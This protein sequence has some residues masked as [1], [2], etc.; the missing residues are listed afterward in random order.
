[1]KVLH[2]DKFEDSNLVEKP[3]HTIVALGQ[4]SRG[5]FAAMLVPSACHLP[6]HMTHFA[7]PSP[8]S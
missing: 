5:T 6:N 4:L 8:R 3:Q 1:M 2:F 7:A